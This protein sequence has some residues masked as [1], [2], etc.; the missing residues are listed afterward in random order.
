MPFA[1]ER[2]R[3]CFNIW[4]ESIMRRVAAADIRNNFRSARRFR[5]AP[6]VGASCGSIGIG[7]VGVGTASDRAGWRRED[8]VRSLRLAYAR[9]IGP[10]VHSG[11]GRTGLDPV[12]YSQSSQ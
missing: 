6:V 3:D 1:G 11:V 7:G 12:M 4:H 9:G 5:H 10:E 8:G 2:R